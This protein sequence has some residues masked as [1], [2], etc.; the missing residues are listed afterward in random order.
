MLK[1]YV[2]GNVCI[3]IYVC[4]I[5][6]MQLYSRKKKKMK[7]NCFKLFRTKVI[8][9]KK[10]SSS[11]VFKYILYYPLAAYFFYIASCNILTEKKK[12]RDSK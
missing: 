7:E 11:T 5:V 2:Y 10:T 3:T 1:S 9:E 4:I 12:K 6:Y 8:I